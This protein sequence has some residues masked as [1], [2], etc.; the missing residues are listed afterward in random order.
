MANNQ[1]WYIDH[2][3]AVAKRW[4]QKR[5]ESDLSMDDFCEFARQTFQKYGWSDENIKAMLKIIRKD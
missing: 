1:G 4:H 2:R 3:N 5:L